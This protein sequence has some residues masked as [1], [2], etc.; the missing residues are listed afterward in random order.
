L[1][2]TA[3]LL[4]FLIGALFAAYLFY[5]VVPESWVLRD[6]APRHLN[7]DPTAQ[8]VNY[9][10]LYMVRVARRF[11]ELG[12]ASHRPALDNALSELGVASGD[13]QPIEGLAM[14]RAAQ[15]FAERENADEA[16]NSQLKNPEGGRFSLQDQNNLKALGDSIDA[17]IKTNTIVSVAKQDGRLWLR[18]IGPFALL[19][20]GLLTLFL[21]DW[22]GNSARN[23]IVA[24]AEASASEPVR[25][26]PSRIIRRRV[27]EPRPVVEEINK[28]VVEEPA[29][30]MTMDT[31]LRPPSTHA[32]VNPSA[33]ETLLGTFNTT[34]AIGDDRYDEGFAINGSMGELIGECGA[35]IV[36]R[37]GLD[38][39]AKVVALAVWVFDKN[40]FQS[41]TK[42]LM[43]DYAYNDSLIRGK[44]DNRGDAI[45]ARNGQ[46]SIDT[47]TLRVE[48]DV[49]G[50]D[51][52]PVGNETNGY[53]E[54]INLQYRV[55]K[56][57]T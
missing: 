37:L 12:G 8:R 39:P 5:A 51:F 41:T 24:E 23:A 42:V 40:D 31:D 11:V 34:Y 49:S 56:K 4:G 19:F 18:L 53:F 55:F 9:R 15:S 43:T 32:P 2:Y 54:K 27:A 25:Q 20:L 17:G 10:D 35:S 28:E 30:E 48:V 33:Q 38:V 13:A 6:V 50:L 21:L 16:N 45:L 36:E 3:L 46:M 52:A 7:S 22:I 57:A 26:V 44:L 14:I 47:S 1:V 29:S